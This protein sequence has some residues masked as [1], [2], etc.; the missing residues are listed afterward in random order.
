MIV[1]IF[2]VSFCS[3]CSTATYKWRWDGKLYKFRI[4]VVCYVR[5]WELLDECSLIVP[6]FSATLCYVTKTNCVQKPGRPPNI[7][8]TETSMAARTSVAELKHTRRRTSLHRRGQFTSL[9]LWS[10][11]IFFQICIAVNTLT[12]SYWFS[13][14]TFYSVSQK[15]PLCLRLSK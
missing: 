11:V 6:L 8:V 14:E 15:G 2:I 3:F 4:W 5:W 12:T 1:L 10:F 7:Y 9:A 13:L